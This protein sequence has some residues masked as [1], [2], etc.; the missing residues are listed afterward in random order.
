M[1]VKWQGKERG[2]KEETVHN[3]TTQLSAQMEYCDNSI[4]LASP[5]SF[6]F[7]EPGSFQRNLLSK[8]QRAG[9]SC[10]SSWS[11]TTF[12]RST[13]R[14]L[15]LAR[16]DVRCG[17]LPHQ[18]SCPYAEVVNGHLR[19]RDSL[20]QFSGEVLRRCRSYRMSLPLEAGNQA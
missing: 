14:Y 19:L 5:G 7:G 8:Y 10:S 12:P 17:V 18:T 15:T 2:W 20:D 3:L 16:Q 13:S 11:S 1:D 6:D 4:S 9:T